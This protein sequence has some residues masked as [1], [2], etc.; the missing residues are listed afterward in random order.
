MKSLGFNEVQ[1]KI[2]II[3]IILKQRVL[4]NIFFCVPQKKERMKL[5]AGQVWFGLKGYSTFLGGN[6]L[7]LQLP[8]S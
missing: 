3:I 7:I 5:H 4:Q 8:Q 6:R 1:L 2:I